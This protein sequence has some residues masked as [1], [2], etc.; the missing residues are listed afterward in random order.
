[1]GII[2]FKLKEYLIF[3]YFRYIWIYIDIFRY[4]LD[5]YIYIYLPEQCEHI[6]SD[7]HAII[8]ALNY[9]NYLF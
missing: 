6:T 8:Q 5:M 4:I 3:F 1:M 9:V 7:S 2:S